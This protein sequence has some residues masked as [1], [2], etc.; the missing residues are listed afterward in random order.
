MTA[1]RNTTNHARRLWDE[2]T[3]GEPPPP[4]V[5]PTAA[6]LAHV[7]A[8]VGTGPE[9]TDPTSE[10]ED[11][12]TALDGAALAVTWNDQP[13]PVD[14]KP[15]YSLA[16]FRG[17][18]PGDPNLWK[19]AAARTLL[20]GR[21]IAALWVPVDD[22]ALDELARVSDG[23][24][25]FDME[26]GTTTGRL[27]DHPY[28]PL[29]RWWQTFGADLWVERQPT[30]PHPGPVAMLPA[31]QRTTTNDGDNLDLIRIDTEPI[32]EYGQLALP[33][34]G[35]RND[36]AAPGWLLDLWDQAGG[37]TMQRGRGAPWDLRLFV[38]ALL[39][40]PR[41]HRDGTARPLVLPARDVIGWLHPGRW[42]NLYRD[43]QQFPEALHNVDRLRVYVPGVGRIRLVAVDVIP[44]TPDELVAFRVVIPAGA[45][46][47]PRIHFPTLTDYGR[48]SAPLYRAYLASRAIV[49]HTSRRGSPVRATHA[50]RARRRVP[51]YTTAELAR[52]VGYGPTSGGR[53]AKTMATWEQLAEDGHIDLRPEGADRWRIYGRPDTE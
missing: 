29:I 18:N 16:T 5:V 34:I 4:W 25:I 7:L 44:A 26:D 19:W 32:P 10:L 17:T 20:S 23:T 36:Q 40:T 53:K 42:R 12:T 38:A 15:G 35:G 1:G 52:I 2:D 22:E 24:N 41:A 13:P 39:W 49:D 30:P 33:G 51:T 9:D 3:N 43:W 37:G 21:T 45:A 50:T 6:D 48:R 47:G 46:I 8:T 28:T 27:I 11:T 14:A 31:L